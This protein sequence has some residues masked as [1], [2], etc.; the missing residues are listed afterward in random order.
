MLAR[1]AILALITSLLLLCGGLLCPCAAAQIEA[2]PAA[3]CPRHCGRSQ[4]PA[5]HD[6][7]TCHCHDGV[8]AAEA[9][10]ASPAVGVAATFA[11]ALPKQAPVWLAPAGVPVPQVVS[12]AS[13]PGW[14]ET[15]LRLRCALIL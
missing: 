8:N 5:K 2:K 4:R 15:L 11:V 9:T 7:K 12:S 1:R 10:P 3:E 6:S 14:C 13:P